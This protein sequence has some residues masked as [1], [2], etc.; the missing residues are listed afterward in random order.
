MHAFSILYLSARIR[1][2]FGQLESFKLSTENMD[3]NIYTRPNKIFIAEYKIT[4]YFKIGL[5]A[6]TILFS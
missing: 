2:E 1:L 4:N 3:N 6:L 5:H